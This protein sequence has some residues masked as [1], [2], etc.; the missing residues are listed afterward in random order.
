MLVRDIISKKGTNVLSVKPGTPIRDAVKLM[1][2]NKIGAIL[3]AEGPDIKGIFS[4][5]DNLRLTYDPDIRV[6]GSTVD[7]G[8]TRE[9]VIAIPSQTVEEVLAIMT[10]RRVRHLP[11]VSDGLLIGIISIGDV[12]KAIS[13]QQKAEILYLKNYIQG[14]M[15]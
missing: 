3:V 12:V 4:E 11:V 6:D 1:L 7:D 13:D 8:M 15:T 5:R 14:D 10:E 9:I 2:D